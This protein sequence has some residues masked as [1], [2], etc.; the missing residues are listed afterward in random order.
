MHNTSNT[1]PVT[2]TNCDTEPIHIPG[3]IQPHG[4]LLGLNP[5]DYSFTH[6]S[7]NSE[8]FL[9]LGATEALTKSLAD[10]LDE[11]SAK[12][13]LSALR[14]IT[15]HPKPTYLQPVKLRYSNTRFDAIA[16]QS[17]SGPLILELEPSTSS[18]TFTAADV[19]RLI[20]NSISAMQRCRSLNER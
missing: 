19:F 13:T 7:Q 5:A 8:K 12:E 6:I 16:H 18:T 11:T 2:L 4:L 14:R 1:N 3:A 20:E 17:P 15:K 10:L 9:G